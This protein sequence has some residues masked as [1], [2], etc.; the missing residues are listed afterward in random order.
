MTSET[1]YFML[2]SPFTHAALDGVVGGVTHPD[3]SPFFSK[4][5]EN[6]IMVFVGGEASGD[7][8]MLSLA[9]DITFLV[10][11]FLELSTSA[12]RAATGED[13]QEMPENHPDIQIAI[14]GLEL[15]RRSELELRRRIL[16]MVR[17]RLSSEEV[18]K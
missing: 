10:H 8:R 7:P 5:T 18:P 3:E 1:R 2:G 11:M 6:T 14:H 15:D 13:A 9:D 17:L 12:R 4:P 16:E